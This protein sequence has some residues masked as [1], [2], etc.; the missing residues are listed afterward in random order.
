MVLCGVVIFAS[1]VMGLYF[2]KKEKRSQAKLCRILVLCAFLGIAAEVAEEREDIWVTENQLRRGENGTGD[3]VVE[4]ELESPGVLKEEHYEITVKEQRLSVAEERT[5]LDAAKKEIEQT[6]LGENES[7]ENVQRTVNLQET[8]QEG[9]VTAEW[10]FDNYRIIRETGEIVPDELL[11][12]G[13]LVCATVCLTCEDEEEEFVFYFKVRPAMIS[14]EQRLLG[15]LNEEL[16]KENMAEERDTIKIPQKLENYTL[17]WK[18]QKNYT[19]I[20]ILM[21]G[22][23][24]VICYPRIEESRRQEARKK[25]EQQLLMQYPDMVSK[26]TLLLGAGMTLAGAWKRIATNYEKKRKN[27]TVSEQPVYEEMIVTYR[28]M[29]SG[30]GEARA[31]ERFGERCGLRQYRRFSNI[32]SQNLKKGARGLNALLEAEAENAFEER[33]SEARK[34]GEEAGTKL[35]LP[36]MLMFGIVV[37]IIMV[38]AII[39]FQM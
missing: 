29:E 20:K 23:F 22:V 10:S 37:F 35:L 38:P 30:M 34:Y 27:N 28:E 7:Y 15:L 2:R 24:V 11:E 39:S 17:N 16:T 4:L 36:M 12:D 14:E 8:Y 3:Y 13:E 32:L 19:A 9:K 5:Y 33:K 26:L 21:L 1:A 25:R 18:L 6:F 31:Y